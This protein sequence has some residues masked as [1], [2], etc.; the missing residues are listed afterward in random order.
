VL[1]RTHYTVDGA[2]ASPPG[3]AVAL[4]KRALAGGM[5]VICLRCRDASDRAALELARALSYLCRRRGATF[6]VAGRV[7]I[8]LAAGADGVNLGPDDMP[9]HDARCLLGQSLLIGA[10]ASTAA[11]AR[12]L[13]TDGASF[14]HTDF[15]NTG[16][17]MDALPYISSLAGAPVIAG[18]AFDSSSLADLVGAGVHGVDLSRLVG[19]EIA[20]NEIAPNGV[21]ADGPGTDAIFG[22]LVDAVAAAWSASEPA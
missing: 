11:D 21:P 18:G 8:A 2:A 20:A 10:Q 5:A 14:I 17:G 19:N 4:A 6:L 9:V 1:G 16:V 3:Q 7:D 12:R 15:K 13:V 22:A